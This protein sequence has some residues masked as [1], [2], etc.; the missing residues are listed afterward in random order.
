MNK[1]VKKKLLKR[2][3]IR[4]WKL[5]KR[6]EIIPFGD[7]FI[8]KVSG[9]TAE[10]VKNNM[11]LFAKANKVI[12]LIRGKFDG[13]NDEFLIACQKGFS[14]KQPSIIEESMLNK[15]VNK[16]TSSLSL[17]FSCKG[18]PENPLI[19]KKANSILE[20]LKEKE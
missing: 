16:N 19:K 2:A 1:R 5:Y 11:E 13:I 14:L 7:E 4:S 18:L 8:A 3:N 10:F 20:L 6:L 15:E 17:E 9:T 12:L